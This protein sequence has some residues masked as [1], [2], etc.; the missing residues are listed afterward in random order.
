M[1]LW[2]ALWD[3]SWSS[4]V[5]GFLGVALTVLLLVLLALVARWL[6]HRLIDR[7]VRRT[8]AGLRP[9]FK[10]PWSE[11]G[12]PAADEEGRERRTARARA[13]GSLLKSIATVIIFVIAF[14]MVISAL[15]LPVAPLLAS[16]G[17]IG[18]AFGIGAQNVVKDFLAGVFMILEDQYGV[19]DVITLGETTGVVE[20]VGLRVT[21][22]RDEEGI[23]WYVRNGEV[24]R[25]GNRSHRG[26]PVT[27]EVTVPAGEDRDR[28]RELLEGLCHEVNDDPEFRGIL[29]STP[30][31]LPEESVRGDNVVFRIAAY[32]TPQEEW[33]VSRD[34]RERAKAHLQ[35]GDVT[36]V[37]RPPWMT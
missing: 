12:E 26:V 24:V 30:K 6:V 9:A 8:E 11:S 4:F 20:A 3:R 25:V 33:R 19:G 37:Y 28:V 35:A 13:M 32:A 34:L 22:L 18:V 31:V 10:T 23:A 14:L 15:G 21:L 2:T 1:T 29:I 16:A 36:V 7:L 17:V 27:V 5:G